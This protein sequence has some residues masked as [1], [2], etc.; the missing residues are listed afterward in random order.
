VPPAVAELDLTSNSTMQ[1]KAY[2]ETTS[3]ILE[4]MVPKIPE[5]DLDS[6]NAFL[7]DQLAK[8]QSREA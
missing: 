1:P 6:E 5:R 3:R 7:K 8:L 2:A 4:I